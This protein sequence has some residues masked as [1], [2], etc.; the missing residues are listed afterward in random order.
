MWP[1]ERIGFLDAI[2]SDNPIFGS[3]CLLKGGE[4]DVV[5]WNGLASHSVLCL[6]GREE[7]FEAVI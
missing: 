7:V 3:V 4:F 6:S 5:S 1:A 2:E